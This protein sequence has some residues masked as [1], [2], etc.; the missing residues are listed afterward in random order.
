MRWLRGV[1]WL[2]PMWPVVRQRL[3]RGVRWVI[4]RGRRQHLRLGPVVSAVARGVCQ[5]RPRRL[6]VV[7]LAVVQAV[8]G[9]GVRVR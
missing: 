8:R 2:T 5:C 6:L 4:P 1:E 9:P 3:I 7:V